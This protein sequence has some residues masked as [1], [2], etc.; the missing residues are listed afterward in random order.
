MAAMFLLQAIPFIHPA[1]AGVALGLGLIP[2]LVHL[3]NRRR[4]VRVPWAA[5]S[6]LLA[7]N[8]RS[9]R[10]VRLEQWLLLLTRVGVILLF[11]LAV[12]RPYVPTS[13]LLPLSAG[14]G[15]RVHRVLLLDNSLS[16]NART[17]TGQS[18]FELAK[19][20]AERLLESFPST[21]AVSIVTLSQPAEAVI[22][23]ATY[24]RRFVR[25]RLA[26]VEPT[27]RATDT[28]GALTTAFEILEDSPLAAGNRAVYLISD[29]PRRLWE[30]EADEGPTAAVRAARRLAD[31]LTDPATNF[32]VVCVAPGVSESVAVTR[33]AAES[34][35]IGVNVPIRIVAEVT[36][37]G[38][39][40]VR[41][42][43][44]QIRRDG[45]IIRREPLPRIEPRGSTVATITTEFSTPGTH[46]IEARIS[47]PDHD[48]LDDD[49]ARYLS[50]EVRDT[51]PVLL[52]DGRPGATRLAGEAGFLATA[53][54]PKVGTAEST[55][56]Q[57]RV[58]IE[59]ELG[60]E[61][62]SD[63]DVVALCDVHRLSA[64]AWKHLEEFVTD[65]GG[66]LIFGGDLLSAENYNRFGY[67]EGKG[68]L[69][70]K[71]GKARVTARAEARGSY[72]SDEYVAFRL[73]DRVHPIVA[74]FVGHAD[75]GLFTVRVDQY[76]PIELDTHRAEVVLR[77]TND[78]AALIASSMGKGRVLYCTTSANMAWT[79]LP[80]KGDY[81][82]LMLSAMA[83]LSPR[84]GDHRNIMVGETIR[85]RLTPVESSLPLR[86]VSPQREN[87]TA[88]VRDA[89][90]P[91]CECRRGN[92]RAVS[93]SR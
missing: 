14:G 34:P 12:A 87:R 1:I 28:V 82:S 38:S 15:S 37:E 50:V 41:D 7:A 74:E 36:N 42:V 6:F 64:E 13:S 49:D 21:D 59:P 61:V 27:Q 77:Y 75:S 56:I 58:V 22:T 80:A 84:H 93:S 45:Q 86:V 40:S 47:P 20:C 76:L 52:V 88:T 48:V 90:P 8:R 89:F 81:V 26:A 55:L 39:S 23:Q 60:G 29:L 62:L 69:P 65:G 19:R 2:I 33:L 71:I 91:Q 85:D 51:R 4:Y 57:P 67:A 53:L 24:D 25:E 43:A 11:G 46:L 31:A 73:D 3:I 30:S 70:G 54:A 32:T 35:L 63:Y 79:N 66:L 9:A 44:L 72:D 68:L 10:R 92:S 17:Q 16:M 5:M 18:R 83:F 78:E